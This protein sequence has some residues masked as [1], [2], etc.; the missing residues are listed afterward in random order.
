MNVRAAKEN[1]VHHQVVR[2]A[3][4]RASASL[5]RFLRLFGMAQ[6]AHVRRLH[7]TGMAQGALAA[8]VKVGMR[9][10]QSVCLASRLLRVL[11]VIRQAEC[12]N[13]I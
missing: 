2:P 4:Q 3:L 11:E 8:Q 5:A 13:A 9:R 12:A 6:H 1:Y 7:P 10:C